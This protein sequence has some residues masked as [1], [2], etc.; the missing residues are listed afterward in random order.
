MGRRVDIPRNVPPLDCA[1]DPGGHIGRAQAKAAA[2]IQRCT[3]FAG[4]AGCATS[5]NAAAVAA[6]MEAAVGGV[7]DAYTEVAYP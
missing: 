1:T 2:Q 3:S 6:C 4:I 5:G 7:V